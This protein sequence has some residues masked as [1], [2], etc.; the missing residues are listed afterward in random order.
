MKKRIPA[1]LLALTMLI[2]LLAGCAASG[3]PAEADAPAADSSAVTPT[4]E[5]TLV[6]KI[7]TNH[8]T[9][10]AV[11]QALQRMAELDARKA[12]LAEKRRVLDEAFAL[13]LEKMR[14]MPAARAK[15][16]ALRTLLESAQGNETVVADQ[17]SA[18]LDDAFIAEANKALAASGRE[19]KLTLS[20]EKKA[21]GGGFL[22]T[23]DGMEVNCSFPAVLSARRLELEADVASAL[24]G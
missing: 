12:L 16:F 1:L 8:S 2:C 9:G 21:L 20:D 24:F 19:G 6:L 18:W 4:R 3:K 7:A 11:E 23:H 14:K 15:E 17:D 5:K 13:A 22:L 10:T